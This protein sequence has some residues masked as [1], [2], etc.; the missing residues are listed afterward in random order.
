LVR[1]WDGSRLSRNVLVT[2]FDGTIT[3]RDFYGL[4]VAEYAQ[5]IAPDH[6]ARYSR[7]E[8]TH[9][10]AMR[11]I[12]SHAPH[13]VA[14]LDA[15][16]ARTDPDPDLAAAVDHLREHDWDLIIV[17]AG[18]SWYIARILAN[19]GVIAEV[20]ANP[21]QPEPGRGLVLELPRDS[22]YFAPDN[23]ID[24]SAVVRAAQRRYEKVAFAG[25]GR[26]D[27]TPAT[28]VDPGLRFARRWLARE[29]ATRGVPFKPFQ[30]WSQI[31]HALAK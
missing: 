19:A 20:H 11:S 4:V 14:A 30:R 3:N 24:K 12:F 22:P 23:G 17:S 2:D 18:C 8:I 26:P 29:L 16:I 7:G 25:D 9:F 27:L 21:G 5:G 13:D 1:I 15:L 6:F 31:P 28:L 10:E